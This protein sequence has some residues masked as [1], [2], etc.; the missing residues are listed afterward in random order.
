VGQGQRERRLSY[1]G[2][3]R[4]DCDPFLDDRSV[5]SS[6]QEL[7][8][9]CAEEWRA[10]SA[11]VC[12][13]PRLSFDHSNGTGRTGEENGSRRL[14]LCESSLHHPFAERAENKKDEEYGRADR[15]EVGR[16]LMAPL[17]QVASA[18]IR[19]AECT[20]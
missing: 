6:G 1:M 11:T 19:P 15:E 2:C 14:P 4:S 20:R 13:A 9:C 17:R 7:V 16:H 3:R 18:L 8:S 12:A 10:R 5:G